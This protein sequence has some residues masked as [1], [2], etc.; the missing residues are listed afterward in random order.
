MPDADAFDR[1]LLAVV[2]A[3]SEKTCG[4]TDQPGEAEAYK[5]GEGIGYCERRSDAKSDHR[6]ECSRT[7]LLRAKLYL[8]GTH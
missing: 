6:P 7:R 1:F 8:D 3:Y 5:K 4:R 2:C